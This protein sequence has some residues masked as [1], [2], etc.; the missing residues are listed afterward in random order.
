MVLGGIDIGTTGCKISLYQDDGTYLAVYSTTYPFARSAGISSFNASVIM[1]AVLLVL[2]QAVEAYPQLDAVGISSFGEAFVLLDQEDNVLYPTLLNTDHRGIE[3][4]R[5]FVACCGEDRICEITGARPH[6]MFSVAKILWMKEQEP[7][8]WRQADK[9]LLMEDFIVFML[10]GVR[11]IDYALASRTQLFDINHLDWSKELLEKTQIS[12]RLFS[13]PVPPGTE[14]GVIRKEIA[15]R[16]GCKTD[17]R[18]ITSAHDQISAAIGAGVLAPGCA[19]DGAGTHECITPVFS[20]LTNK[21][22]MY[23]SNLAIVPFVDNQY[24][25]YAFLFTGCA[26][27]EWFID[28]LAGHT[29]QK[30]KEAGKSVFEMLE[31][32]MQT[33]PTGILV[34]PHFDGAATPYMDEGSKGAFVGMSVSTKETDLYQAVMEGIAFEMRFNMERAREAGLEIR[35]LHATGG[36]ANSEKWLQIKAD[37]LNV[38]IRTMEN[39][40]A[41]AIGTIILM[42]KALGVYKSLEEGVRR[43]VAYGK[44]FSPN[45]ENFV[46]YQKVYERYQKLYAAVRP[47]IT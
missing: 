38:P 8:I 13:K 45:P 34:L 37:I 20:S 39:P 7:A 30:A 40:Q 3:Q 14:A 42:G 27:T 16:I 18:V 1:E 15:E 25:T 19:V 28:T 33:E 9:L 22:P 2:K 29:V 11:Q 41:G 21:T 32:G 36:G 17:L 24:V 23:D 4:V 12:E 35:E 46:K 26:L 31:A 10:T 6:S 5:S 43:L 47:L 44:V